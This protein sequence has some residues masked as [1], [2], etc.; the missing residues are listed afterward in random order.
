MPH[1][2]PATRQR[3]HRRT[4]VLVVLALALGSVVGATPFGPG[5]GP[6]AAFPGSSVTFEGHGFGHG[7][8]LS[9]YGALG[10]A[11]AGWDFRRILDHYYG[12]TTA[13]SRPNEAI[14]V[15]LRVAD[16]GGGRGTIDGQPLVLD[17]GQAF[18][19]GSNAFAAG[20]AARVTRTPAGW[21]V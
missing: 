8:G 7:R 12:G 20:E 16:A 19:I 11:L 5:T 14:D 13:G 2:S 10:Y 3:R 18:S 9:Q 6:V 15:H 17:S 1:A 4:G 21:R